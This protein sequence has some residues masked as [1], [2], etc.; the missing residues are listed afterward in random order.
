[1]KNINDIL[2][3][4][5]YLSFVNYAKSKDVSPLSA[6]DIRNILSSEQYSDL[7][8]KSLIK[9]FEK[10]KACHLCVKNNLI[11]KFFKLIFTY[12]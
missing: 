4:L 9:A 11:T 12:Y 8:P 3:N 2:V 1:M 6:G 10:K 5:K 7:I